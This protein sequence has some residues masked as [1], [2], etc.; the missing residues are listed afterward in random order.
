MAVPEI[1]FGTGLLFHFQ[2][3]WTWTYLLR[4]LPTPLQYDM[5]RVLQI[6]PGSVCRSRLSNCLQSL[7]H[8]TVEST[9]TGN[10]PSVVTRC[11]SMLTRHR[12]W[13]SPQQPVIPDKALSVASAGREVCLSLWTLVRVLY[14]AASPYNCPMVAICQPSVRQKGW[15]WR[16]STS[17]EIFSPNIKGIISL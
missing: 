2:H 9:W 7:Y 6:I 11:S 12:T 13:A 5:W 4:A 15:L 8:T 16:W 10:R 1:Q 14:S 17:M 3:P